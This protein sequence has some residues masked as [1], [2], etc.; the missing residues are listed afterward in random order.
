MKGLKIEV[1]GDWLGPGIRKQFCEDLGITSE[2]LDQRI[3]LAKASVA[4]MEFSDHGAAIH[5]FMKELG[6]AGEDQPYTIEK[7]TKEEIEEE[8]LRKKRAIQD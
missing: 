8:L 6:I 1:M 5:H 2:Q 4:A 3:Q 7:M